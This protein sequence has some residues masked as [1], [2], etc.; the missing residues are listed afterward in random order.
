MNRPLMT[1]EAY[2]L[3]FQSDDQAARAAYTEMLR[4]SAILDAQLVLDQARCAA[5]QKEVA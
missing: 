2:R 3:S 5:K 4:L 1:Y